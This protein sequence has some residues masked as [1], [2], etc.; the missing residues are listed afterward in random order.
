MGLAL[1]IGLLQGIQKGWSSLLGGL[2]YWV[3]TLIFMWRVSAYAGARAAMRF[4]I[5]FFAGEFGKLILS[6]VLFVIAVKYLSMDM[7]FGLIGLIGAIVAFWV[8]SATLLLSSG[9]RA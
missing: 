1:V 2:A 6:A 9:G 8:A 5:A 7:L 3:P 4:M